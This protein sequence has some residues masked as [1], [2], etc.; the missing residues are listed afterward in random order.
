MHGFV[1]G[2]EYWIT[3]CGTPGV[4]TRPEEI[5]ILRCQPLETIVGSNGSRHMVR[6]RFA[7]IDDD[8]Q[9][10]EDGVTS[11]TVAMSHYGT[12]AEKGYLELRQGMYSLHLELG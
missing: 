6:V 2:H 12:L 11:F 10:V 4:C 1:E 8:L 5:D 9:V 3:V 7:S